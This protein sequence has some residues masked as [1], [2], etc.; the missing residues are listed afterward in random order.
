MTQSGRLAGRVALVTGA[1]RGIGAGIA[2]KLAADGFH[3][4]LNFASNEAKAR[5]LS[6]ATPAQLD[7]L[8]R[9]IEATDAEVVVAATPAD[10]AGLLGIAKPVVRARYEFQDL[11][12]PGLWGSVE[13][14]LASRGLA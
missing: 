3:V 12:S 5:D 14:F 10:L 2:R 13:H 6:R 4:L 9:T 7:A 1:S 8:R 11:D